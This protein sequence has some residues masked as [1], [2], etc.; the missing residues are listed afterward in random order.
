[1]NKTDFYSLTPLHR[2]TEFGHVDIVQYL[3]QAGLHCP[4]VAS[5]HCIVL[6]LIG[7]I[8]VHYC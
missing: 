5:E 4:F 7:Y 3:L 8:Y 1:M 6:R 2:A